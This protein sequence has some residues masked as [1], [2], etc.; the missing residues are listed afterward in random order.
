MLPSPV[1]YTSL[2]GTTLY[3]ELCMCYVANCLRADVANICFSR[4]VQVHYSLWQSLNRSNWFTSLS[5]A[6]AMASAPSSSPSSLSLSLSVC[7]SLSR[8]LK[9]VQKAL[10]AAIDNPQSPSQ[11]Q[12]LQLPRLECGNY[13]TK[14]GLRLEIAYYI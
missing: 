9:L 10:V 2:Q 4:R 3:A 12:L 5:Q 14:R 7:L 13:T 1:L 8:A 6:L 11:P